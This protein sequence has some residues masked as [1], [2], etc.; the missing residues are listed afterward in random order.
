MKTILRKALS[1]L[2]LHLL[3]LPVLAQ[4]SAVK[5]AEVVQEE[6]KENP[7]QVI[8]HVDAKSFY[9]AEEFFYTV[10]VSGSDEV[11]APLIENLS[12]FG[13]HKLGEEALTKNGKKGYAIR[14]KL[15]PHEAGD[16]EIPASS[17]LVGGELYET[18]ALAIKVEKAVAFPGLILDIHLSQKQAYVGEPILAT[19]TWY[20]SIPL[21]GFKAVDLK[22]PLLENYA[23][24]NLIAQ[25]SPLP[26]EKNT[27]GLPVSN[28][29]VITKRG[30]KTVNGENYEFLQFRKVIIPRIAGEF[31][32]EGARLLCSY[33]HPTNT[34]KGRRNWQP[35]YPSF[36]NNNFFESEVQGKFEKFL[37]ESKPVA[38]T[39]LDLPTEGKPDDFYGIVGKTSLKVTAEPTTVEEGAPISLELQLGE[40]K[41]LEVLELPNLIEQKAFKHSFSV[42]KRESLGSIENKLKLFRRTLRPLRTDVK[43]IP[44]IRIPYFDPQTKT[45]G[46]AQNEPI[47]IT[48]LPAQ[49]VTAFDADLAGGAI[50]KNQVEANKDG[51][52]QNQLKD[53]LKSDTLSGFYLLAFLLPPGVFAL[54]YFLTYQQRL[55]RRDPEKARRLSAYKNFMRQGSSKDLLNF[56][57][58]VRQY[59]ADKLNLVA[60]AHVYDDL[61]WRLKSVLNQ[62]ELNELSALYNHFDQQHFSPSPCEVSVNELAGRSK[63]LIKAING[64]LKHV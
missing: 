10:L 50:L 19:F 27:I 25:G 2:S 49:T 56:E 23:F 34:G 17:V 13:V 58:L 12:H 37:A 41:F 55:E 47:D 15:V 52:R 54:F 8:A 57:S 59:F 18:E 24:G 30:Q 33:V 20:S 42:P 1:L 44:A 43:F 26:G 5:P 45:Y 29:R 22:I 7:I 61:E 60:G 16:L 64:R 36:F 32:I 51:I 35:M 62:A 48:V 40:N 14:Y 9:M 63:N 21:Y 28:T 39:I 3:M 11:K 53:V 38:I 46:V 6:V 4:E 31:E